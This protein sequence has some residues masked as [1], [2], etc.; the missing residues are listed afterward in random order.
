MDNVTTPD[1]ILLR[2]EDGMSDSRVTQITKM[3]KKMHWEDMDEEE[4]QVKEYRLM[5]KGPPAAPIKAAKF[6]YY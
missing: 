2:C 1:I 6:Y 4:E 5:R 3:T